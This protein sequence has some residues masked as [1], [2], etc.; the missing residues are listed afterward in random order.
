M[1]YKLMKYK[2]GD[3]IGDATEVGGQRKKTRKEITQW[4]D[5]NI[6]ACKLDW[7]VGFTIKF[8]NSNMIYTWRWIK[9]NKEVVY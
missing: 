8:R 6:S 2:A 4:V 5:D 9:N 7:R 3:E 1:R